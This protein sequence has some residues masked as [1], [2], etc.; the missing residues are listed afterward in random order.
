M[1]F[2]KTHAIKCNSCSLVSQFPF[3]L[4]SH[5]KIQKLN[6]KKESKKKSPKKTTNKSDKN[7]KKKQIQ[8]E[9]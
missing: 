1:Q 5:K 6:P 7:L 4:V 9:I 2:K 3:I 8:K